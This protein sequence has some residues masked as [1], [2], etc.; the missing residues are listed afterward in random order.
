MR[1]LED[2]PFGGTRIQLG[3]SYQGEILD[4]PL[5]S[6]GAWQM[7]GIR[8]IT[9]GQTAYQMTSGRLWVE[10]MSADAIVDISVAPMADVIR[11]VGPHHLDIAGAKIKA[12]GLPQGPFEHLPGAPQGAAYP[13]LWKHNAKRERQLIVKPDSHCKIREINGTVPKELV[14]KAHDRWSVA[15]RAHYNLDLQF[16][17]QS[18]IV[19]MTE[20]TSIGG[21][22]WPTVLFNNSV[23]E[24]TFAI[25]SNSTFGLL[26]HWWMSNK[27][28]AGRG[29]STVTSIPTFTTL[30][31]RE[32]TANQHTTARLAF[33]A[34]SEER[35]LPF[36]QIN[37]DPARA[38]LDRRLIVDVLGLSPELCVQGG[39]IERLRAKLAAEPQIHSNKKN[40]SR[41]H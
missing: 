14:S 18:L 37:E 7:V 8:D 2:G 19:A 36:D 10:G 23:H 31:S 35:F 22:A 5:P 9:L 41:L 4:C 6:E 24:F 26:C 32:L 11:R 30:D 17:S 15:A 13:C 40:S 34:M 28:Q 3:D 33:E 21:R 16:N 39:P 20:Q 38:E 27:S 29:T 25:W 12:D 1:R